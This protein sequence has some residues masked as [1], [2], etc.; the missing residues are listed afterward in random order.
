MHR[1]KFNFIVFRMGMFAL[2][3]LQM[4]RN[5]RKT[6]TRCFPNLEV[7]LVTQHVID[8]ELLISSRRFHAC[9]EFPVNLTLVYKEWIENI[10]FYF[11]QT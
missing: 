9:I 11:P 3:R 2:K 7:Q 4:G 8:I 6:V 1:R 5:G 10:D